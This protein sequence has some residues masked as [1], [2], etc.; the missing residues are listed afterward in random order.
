M[1]FSYIGPQIESLLGWAQDSWIS[2]T[3]WADR[4]HA[5]D[6]DFTVSFCVEQSK[7]GVDHELDYRALTKNNGHIWI[8]DVVHVVRNE[9]G[10]VESLVGF[11]F[12]ITE[13]KK[14]EEKLVRLQKELE[15]L[16]YNDPLTGIAN[17]RKFNVEYDK[18]WQ[19]AISNQKP[20]SLIIIDIDCFK[21]YNDHY[22]HLI[23]DESLINVAQTLKLGVVKPRD[24]VSRFGGEEF[25]L[26]LPETD[27]DAANHIASRCK[28]LIEDLKIA[29]AGSCV[30]DTLT[31]SLGVG[32][33]VPNY[34]SLP[35]EFIRSVDDLLYLAK[36]NGRNCV[37]SELF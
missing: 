17:R 23:G 2:A 15:A 5:E 27:F 3:D 29:H 14:T 10:E 9:K 34:S 11:M 37:E 6:R 28:R 19:A 12:D 35:Q 36:K 18:E 26:L 33:V 30:S 13:R 21:Q 7:N 32:T 22:G 16:S 20:L 8:R 24:L 31:I 25:I 4:I 1:T